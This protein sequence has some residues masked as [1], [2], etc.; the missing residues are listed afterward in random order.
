MICNVFSYLALSLYFTLTWILFSNYLPCLVDCIRFYTWEEE[1]CEP[2]SFETTMI[3][4]ALYGSS[5]FFWV[6]GNYKEFHVLYNWLIV[7]AHVIVLMFGY[8]VYAQLLSNSL[9]WQVTL[10]CSGG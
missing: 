3:L 5:G 8:I 6:S 4:F 2:H 7:T 9:T 1:Y 10:I